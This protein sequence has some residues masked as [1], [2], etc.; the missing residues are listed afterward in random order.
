M[1][2]VLHHY[3][4]TLPSI[5]EP[6]TSYFAIGAVLFQKEY[7][8]QPG[9]FYSKTMTATELNYDIHHKAMLAIV[10]AFQEWR[11]TWKEQSILFWCSLTT[12]TW[13]TLLQLKYITPPG[14][15]GLG[16]CWI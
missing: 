2:P 12:R 6:D 15:M 13:S 8:V 9:T 7:R 16:I 5:V 3:D 14:K 10:S 1:A 11:S 4:P